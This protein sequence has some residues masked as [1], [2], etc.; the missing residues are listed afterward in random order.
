MSTVGR[1]VGAGVVILSS[2]GAFALSLDPVFGPDH[3][4]LVRPTMGA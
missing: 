1:R 3:R 2:S 4:W